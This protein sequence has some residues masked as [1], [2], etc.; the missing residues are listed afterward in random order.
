MRLAL[1][2]ALLGAAAPAA[3]AESRPPRHLMV[4]GDSLA[5]DNRPY[6]QS[7]LPGWDIRNDFSFARTAAETARD[8]RKDDEEESL[9]PVIHVSSGTGDDP[10]HVGRFRRAVRRVMRLAGPQRCVVWA[11]VYRVKFD[12][13]TFEAINLA[14]AGEGLRWPNLRVVDWRDMVNTHRYWLV[15]F[16]HVNEEGNRAR[17]AAVAHE[18]RVCRGLL[19]AP[20]LPGPLPP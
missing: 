20:L 12:L 1:A 14:L 6:L 8:L 7:E 15:D 19:T 3:L 9:P 13:P 10:S 4:I 5:A 18:V 16:I 17:A 2:L 11:N